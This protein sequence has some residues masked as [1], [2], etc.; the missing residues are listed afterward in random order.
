MIRLILAAAM[1]AA[2]AAMLYAA[3]THVVDKGRAEVREEYAPLITK[4]DESK[5]APAACAAE[6]TQAIAKNLE[7]K[8]SYDLL[9]TESAKCSAETQK[10]GDLT[11]KAEL[12]KAT[13]L[14]RTEGYR[15]GLRERTAGNEQR[16]TA[17]APRPQTCEQAMQSVGKALSSIVERRIRFALG[18][19]E[20]SPDEHDKV[21]VK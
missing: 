3:Y 8:A 9:Q 16:L 14:A 15:A 19:D 7:L 12:D 13:N 5:R 1:A 17:P 11:A 10:G 6:W 21:N 20:E 18:F 4:C 2:I